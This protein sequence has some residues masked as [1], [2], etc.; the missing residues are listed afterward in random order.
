MQVVNREEYQE[1]GYTY[2]KI[3]YDNGYIDIH[4]KPEPF[5]PG[6]EPEPSPAPVTN[7]DIMNK[8]NDMSSEQVSKASLDAAYR[9]GVNSYD[10]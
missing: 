6:P 5:E 10:E 8:L 2:E 9:E 1:N 4:I 3:T 7:E